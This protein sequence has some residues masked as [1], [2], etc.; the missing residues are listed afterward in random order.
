MS[1]VRGTTKEFKRQTA[2]WWT[3]AKWSLTII[4]LFF[5][6]PSANASC[7]TTG[8]TS[9]SYTFTA[10]NMT[11]N[12]DITFTGTFVCTQPSTS[13]ICQLIP[14]ASGCSAI[15]V[16]PYVCSKVIF[17]G[18]TSTV[19][20]N[21]LTYSITNLNIGGVSR[22]SSISSNSWYGPSAVVASNNIISYSVTIRVPTN[23]SL[24][25][26]N[27]AGS[28]T[29][30]IQLYLDMQYGSS[31]CE[32]DSGG[33]WDASNKSLTANYIMPT[34]CQLNSTTMVNF[35]T[36]SDIGTAS[37]NYDS[38]GAVSTTCNPNTAYTLYLGDG[39][40]RLN[41]GMR[42]MANG[43]DYIAY[44]L[45]KTSPTSSSTVWDS[46]GGTTTIG[47]SGGISLTGT[48]IAQIT[49]V[50]GR[51][52]KGANIPGTTGTYSDTVIVTVTY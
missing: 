1:L 32:G 25:S 10:G 48:G 33:G 37:K 35:G 17:T 44:Q 21:S 4:A 11:S 49:T 51:I 14:T 36:I 20:S 24:L 19:N 40:Q 27:S 22:S 28:Y 43:T 50:Y 13:L 16:S 45:Y 15:A 29:G 47:G 6:I 46:T 9:S 38:N 7:V 26:A 18:T 52:A 5:I 2:I 42:Q 30:V 3:L 12:A 39:N 34:Y 31:S 23:S 41:S 8:D